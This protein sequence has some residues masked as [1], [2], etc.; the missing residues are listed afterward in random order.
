LAT[1]TSSATRNDLVCRAG[2]KGTRATTTTSATVSSAAPN[3]DVENL[4]GSHLEIRLD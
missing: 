2:F 4:A 1:S 3:G